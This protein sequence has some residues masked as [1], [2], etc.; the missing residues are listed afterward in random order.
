MNKNTR[1]YVKRYYGLECDML[2]KTKDMDKNEWLEQRKKGIT[3]TD[4]GSIVGLNKWSSSTAVYLK[5]L[6]ELGETEEN[7]AMYWGTIL[8]PKIA[9]EF[10]KR[11]KDMKVRAV[12][13][14]L[15]HP[16]NNWALA[17]IDRLIKDQDG[18]RGILEIKTASEYSK[19]LW[20]ADEVP[21]AYLV[22]I[23]W[24]MYVTGTSYGYFA[25]LIGGQHYIQKRVERDDELIELLVSESEKFWK[26]NVLKRVSPPV[27]AYSADVLAKLTP[28]SNG[29]SIELDE[30]S[31]T[32]IE[33]IEMLK[34]EIKR[35]ELEKKVSENQL[36]EK[37]GENEIGVIR[38]RKVI[39]KT[40]SRT[41]VDSKKLKEE[42][43][44][45]YNQYLKTTSYRKFDIR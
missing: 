9:E 16:E 26:E 32:S 33:N 22:Q 29:E 31:L 7:E 13:A 15:M 30:Q 6:G 10:S 27:D 36:K 5:K 8:E 24:Y 28:V 39:W 20:S 42:K 41:S 35:L 40:I 25:A 12:N 1:D 37:L 4:V 43:P 19:D 38:D 2:C 23:Q 18:N 45:I 14:M 44:E 34:N 11:N 3:G 21:N 17:N